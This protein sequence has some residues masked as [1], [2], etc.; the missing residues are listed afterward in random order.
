VPVVRSAIEVVQVAAD[1]KDVSVRL[2]PAP[3]HA[4]VSGDERR[5]RQVVWNLL[6]N[7][8]KFTNKGGRVEVTVTAD[9][10]MAEIRVAD[11]GIGITRD[12]LP[13]VFE[14]FWQLDRSPGR[15]HAGLGLGLAIV[16]HLA[17]GH[18]GSVAAE[19]AGEGQGA[20]F[21]VR[22]PLMT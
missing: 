22:I 16:R 13:H 9:D 18:G 17:E 2:H 6:S 19:S 20:A 3:P 7:A 12:A 1:A 14:R 5:L 15:L 8:I 11:T 4:M 21:T 10:A